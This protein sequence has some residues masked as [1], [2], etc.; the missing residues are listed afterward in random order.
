MGVLK[1]E[2]VGDRLTLVP[3]AE[4]AALFDA[5]KGDKLEFEVVENGSLVLSGQGRS[6]DERLARGQAFLE[7]YR[8]TF[9]DLAK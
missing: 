5:R 2:I 1:V 8:G 7:R 9:E 4:A 6:F 3:D